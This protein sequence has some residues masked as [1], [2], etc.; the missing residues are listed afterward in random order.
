MLSLF[1]VWV[2]SLVSELRSPKL[3]NMTKKKE[4]RK[5]QIVCN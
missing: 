5:I 3:C 4:K 2:Q 1:R